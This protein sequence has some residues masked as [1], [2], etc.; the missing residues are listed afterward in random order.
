MPTSTAVF[1]SNFSGDLAAA[2]AAAGSSGVIYLD[3]DC[4]LSGDLTLVS[5][6]VVGAGGIITTASFNLTC[7]SFAGNVPMLNGADVYTAPSPGPAQNNVTFFEPSDSIKEIWFNPPLTTLSGGAVQDSADVHIRWMNSFTGKATFKAAFGIHHSAVSNKLR[8][9]SGNF[10]T[11][12]LI[13]AIYDTTITC[14]NSNC[15]V[16][17]GFVAGQVY[18]TF[19][20]NPSGGFFQVGQPVSINGSDGS[21]TLVIS[22]SG[23][24][25]TIMADASP[26]GAVITQG[27]VSA[28]VSSYARCIAVGVETGADSNVM[29]WTRM[30]DFFVRDTFYGYGFNS[31][32]TNN[33]VSQG[34]YGTHT[35][36]RQQNNI[37]TNLRTTN[38]ARGCFTLD[39]SNGNGYVN[40][41][42]FVGIHGNDDVDYPLIIWNCTANTF[43]NSDLEGCSSDA[44]IYVDSACLDQT[45]FGGVFSNAA[46]SYIWKSVANGTSGLTDGTVAAASEKKLRFLGARFHGNGSFGYADCTNSDVTGIAQGGNINEYL[47]SSVLTADFTRN[48]TSFQ[49]TGLLVGGLVAG[50]TYEFEADLFVN[51]NST[52]GHKYCIS[53]SNGL[54]ASSIRYEILAIDN[55]TNAIVLSE[56]ATALGA[57]PAGQSG[58]TDVRT[59]IKGT[60]TVGTSGNLIVDFGN[61]T[62]S[63]VATVRA[64]STFKVFRIG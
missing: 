58:A 3:A 64:L 36:S 1:V 27:G 43:I 21:D 4:T 45:F 59:S 15:H 51:P 57:G 42:T 16:F 7:R 23:M 11:V 47:E 18:L 14:Q 55:Q 5:P 13:G 62:N 31:D 22:A 20:G 56:V 28:T 53:T 8:M 2:D 9:C 54:V 19:T 29:R 40:E 39:G 63:N 33:A 46:T 10:Q 12:D 38:V 25:A 17:G 26:A 34:T 37:Y 32:G 6:L 41:C 30:E 44:L 50:G 52:G 35:N 61:N 48:G 24:Q 60:L 49:P